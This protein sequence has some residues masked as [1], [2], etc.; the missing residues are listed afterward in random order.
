MFPSNAEFCPPHL[1]TSKWQSCRGLT[2]AIY[3]LCIEHL[4]MLRLSGESNPRPPALQ[5]ST[6][7]K[8]PFDGPY[9]VAIRDLTC[10]ATTPPQ[11]GG[12]WL[13]VIW[14][15]VEYV[16]R[17]DRMHVAA[18]ELRITLGSPL[19]RGLT[20][21]V[22]ILCIEHLRLLRLSGETNPGPPALQASTLWK[23]PLERPYLVAIWDLT[24]A[25]TKYLFGLIF[26]CWR[27]W[28]ICLAVCIAH[29]ELQMRLK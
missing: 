29:T 4:R 11:D 27:E 17:S 16:W 10:A 13:S 21:A 20:R 26:E 3:I 8:E 18:W 6:L 9:L 25:A 23:E 2:R 5:A 12:L 24:C 19:C 22:Y 7:W 28:S 15:R 1:E 14:L